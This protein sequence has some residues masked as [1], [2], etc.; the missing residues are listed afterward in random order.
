M[1]LDWYSKLICR[2]NTPSDNDLLHT[3]YAYSPNLPAIK[4][5]R[6]AADLRATESTLVLNVVPAIVFFD[7]AASLLKIAAVLNHVVALNLIE[8]SSRSPAKSPKVRAIVLAKPALERLTVLA[9]EL[10]VLLVSPVAKPRSPAT[11]ES[12]LEGLAPAA[13]SPTTRSLLDAPAGLSKS[14]VKSKTRLIESRP[15]TSGLC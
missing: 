15:K 3:P 1:N 5:I 14:S 4:L 11:A 2:R 7:V 10:L 6:V 13:W 8:W 9:V 12:R